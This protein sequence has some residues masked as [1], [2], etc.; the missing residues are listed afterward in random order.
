M[1]HLNDDGNEIEVFTA[2]EVQAK[3]DAATTTAVKAKE[4]EFGKTKSQL[5]AELADARKALGER[6]GE[7][8]QFRE[9]HA[10]VVAKLS[11]AERTIYENQLA[12]KKAD[13][14]RVAD[15]KKRQDAVVDTVL[16]SKAG[17]DEKL[18]TKMKDTW[19]IINVNATTPEEIE[20]KVMMVLGAIQTTE[21]DLLAGVA[22]FSGS[23]YMPPKQKAS[24]DEESFGNTEKGKAMAKDLGLTLEPPAKKK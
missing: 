20:K 1:L 13:D 6:A 22:G 8:K 17:K 11:L 5:D 12:Q 23:G 19:G 24:G 16:R 21:P 14:T 15:D 3:I 10:D 7:F 18:F 9:L 4:D 2:E